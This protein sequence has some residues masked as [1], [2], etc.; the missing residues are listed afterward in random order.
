MHAIQTNLRSD[1][2]LQL[3][4]QLQR[5]QQV[6][7][8]LSVTKRAEFCDLGYLS[9]ESSRN[10]Q[11]LGQLKLKLLLKHTRTADRGRHSYD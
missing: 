9:S 8:A 5:L 1:I 11:H 4:L 7:V 6:C 3:Q 2:Q 10:N